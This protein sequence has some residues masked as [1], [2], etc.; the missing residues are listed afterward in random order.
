MGSRFEGRRTTGNFFGS[1]RGSW[2]TKGW[3]RQG[4]ITFGVLSP[5]FSYR[6]LVIRRPW[7]FSCSP[8]TP[9]Y[10]NP[11]KKRKTNCDESSEP[12]GNRMTYSTQCGIRPR[13]TFNKDVQAARDTLYQC[14]MEQAE[15]RSRV[16]LRWTCH[17]SRYEYSYASG[18]D[19]CVHVTSSMDFCQSTWSGPPLE[20]L[21]G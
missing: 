14:N 7:R 17:G 5:T 21:P 13:N 15:K 1:T 12:H 4:W 3:L 18:N 9:C 11:S 16:F 8:T 10:P 6:C 19:V 2:L 20:A